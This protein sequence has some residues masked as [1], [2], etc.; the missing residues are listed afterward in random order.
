MTRTDKLLDTLDVVCAALFPIAFV[1]FTAMFVVLL[2]HDLLK[3]A[4]R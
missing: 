2:C 1:F 3:G 4:S